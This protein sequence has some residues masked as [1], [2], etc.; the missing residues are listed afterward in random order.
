MS[1]SSPGV[2][3]S[4][5][6]FSSAKADRLWIQRVP[7]KPPRPPKRKRQ[8]P[9]K[10]SSTKPSTSRLP[11][12][13]SDDDLVEKPSTKRKRTQPRSKLRT[14]SSAPASEPS[15]LANGTRARAAKVQAN[16]KLDAQAKELAEFQRQAAAVAKL[17]SSSRK[18]HAPSPRKTILGTRASARLRGSDHTEDD[19]WQPI[20]A[21]WLEETVNSSN[22]SSVT[23]VTRRSLRSKG[24]A[25]AIIS[26]SEAD[27]SDKEAE[28]GN[29]RVEGSRLQ[30]GSLSDDSDSSELTE[31]SDI[32]P[33][34]PPRNIEQTD[35][36]RVRNKTQNRLANGKAGTSQSELEKSLPEEENI[37]VETTPVLPNDFIEWEA[38]R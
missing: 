11:V 15:P 35:P 19:E 13:D 31:L 3:P 21:E 2:F 5:S 24:K 17:Q 33:E 16:K 9:R 12:E 1:T 32:E 37:V 30:T 27:L 23:R 34:S 26:E 8:P 10:P 22:E 14:R 18:S 7:P 28:G 25:R 6:P 4:H 29:A 38:V 20:P 36:T